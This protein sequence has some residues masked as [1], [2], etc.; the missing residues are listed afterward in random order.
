MVCEI[1]CM[2]C[3]V[4]PTPFNAEIILPPL[5]IF[6]SFVLNWLYIHQFI[7]HSQS[8]FTNLCVCFYANATVGFFLFVCFFFF[9]SFLI[10]DLWDLGSLTRDWTQ[11]LAEKTQNPNQWTSREFPIMLLVFVWVFFMCVF[12]I[13][14]YPLVKHLLEYFDHIVIGLLPFLLSFESSLC[15]LDLYP[16]VK[17]VIC[18]YLPNSPS[19]ASAI[20]EPWT[21]W[22]SSWF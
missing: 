22:C 3:P 19:Q 10:H 18:K 15:I 16:F 8:W 9:F 17:Y 21:S 14:I 2:V 13:H 6:D 1:L 4:F 5:Y 11:A 20:R 12:A 7:L